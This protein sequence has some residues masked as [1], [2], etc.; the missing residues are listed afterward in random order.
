ME[1]EVNF[2][3]NH[4][5]DKAIKSLT[6]ALNKC[7]KYGLSGGVYD[8]SFCVWPS[9]LDPERERNSGRYFDW[10]EAVDDRGKV[11]SCNMHLDGGA[12]N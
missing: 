8:G 10:F 4:D 9:E 11:I 1:R 6:R 3:M 5:Q 7:A 12:G 2:I